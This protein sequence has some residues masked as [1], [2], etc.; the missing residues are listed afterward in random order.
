MR[1]AEEEKL[2]ALLAV[3]ENELVVEDYAGNLEPT[4]GDIFSAGGR[5][6]RIGKFFGSADSQ[7]LGTVGLSHDARARI[8]GYRVSKGMI[9][10]MMRV[11]DVANRLVGGFL[12]GLDDVSGFFGEVCINNYDVILEND[13]NVVAA[14]EGDVRS[15]RSDGGIAKEDSRRNLLNLVE[16]QFGHFVSPNVWRN[17]KNG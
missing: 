9:P 3:V 13:P 15:F 17:A 8:A 1:V 6:A 11:K 2:D 7:N 5:L 16:L 10:V 14:S 12:D 4:F